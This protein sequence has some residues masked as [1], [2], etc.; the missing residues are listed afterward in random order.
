MCQG[1]SL[2]RRKFRLQT[3]VTKMVCRSVDWPIVRGGR[4]IT[5]AARRR[6]KG[7]KSPAERRKEEGLC[8]RI[9]NSDAPPLPPRRPRT[10]D[11]IRITTGIVL[12]RPIRK[13]SPV[14]DK[15]LRKFRHADRKFT[16]CTERANLLFSKMPALASAV[17]TENDGL[18]RHL[19]SQDWYDIMSR[20]YHRINR[21]VAE[22]GITR[23]VLLAR[24]F[25]TVGQFALCCKT[26]VGFMRVYG[27]VGMT[28]DPY[29]L[30][31]SEP[32]C[33]CDFGRVGTNRRTCRVHGKDFR[34]KPR[35]ARRKKSRR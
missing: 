18:L 25:K 26:L 15:A 7:L 19:K 1:A 27:A 20:R 16:W 17:M 35:D 8:S 6:S 12:S 28:W 13:D 2:R 3:G 5:W 33:I 14:K 10:L 29:E 24:P 22:L 30:S 21:R 23:E 31:Y 34:V 9:G 11:E 4:S 32:V